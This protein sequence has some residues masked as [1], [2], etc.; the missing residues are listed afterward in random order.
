MNNPKLLVIWCEKR[1]TL[2]A[3]L[4]VIA[5]LLLTNLSWW[6]SI[7]T[8]FIEICSRDESSLVTVCM[9]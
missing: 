8:W 3:V 7:A 6:P 4:L 1:A 2:I 5:G 9:R